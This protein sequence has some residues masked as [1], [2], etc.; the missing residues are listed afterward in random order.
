MRGQASRVAVVYKLVT[1]LGGG[2]KEKCWSYPL[3]CALQKNASKTIA[4]SEEETTSSAPE[5]HSTA[6]TRETLQND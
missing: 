1:S 4:P 3:G 2:V 6:A 5:S